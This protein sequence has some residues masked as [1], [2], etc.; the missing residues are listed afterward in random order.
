MTKWAGVDFTD[1]DGGCR[2]ARKPSAFREC[3]TRAARPVH[4]QG[5]K[6]AEVGA[7]GRY[8]LG[9]ARRHAA[10][11]RGASLFVVGADDVAR[12]RRVAVGAQLSGR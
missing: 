8:D 1:P 5:E 10:Q 3:R 9:T 11:Y 12:L 6:G 2:W 4:V 7:R